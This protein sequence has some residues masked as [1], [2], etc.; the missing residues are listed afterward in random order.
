MKG[1]E[2]LEEIIKEAEERFSKASSRDEVLRL[3]SEFLGRKGSFTLLSKKIRDLPPE[4]RPAFGALLNEARRKL[5]SL[6]ESAIRRIEEEERKKIIE[7][8]WVDVT[9]PGR[10]YPAGSLHPVMRVM[11]EIVD[12]FV[13][14]GFEV[15]EGPEL[16]LDYYNFEALNIPKDHPARDMQDTFYI[17]DEYLLRTHTSPVQIRVMESQKPPIKIIA[18]GTVYRRDFDLTHVPMFHQVEG[19]LV[20]EGV[21]FSQLKGVLEVF[22]K[23]FFGEEIKV[24][25]RPSYFPF[26]EP[27][28][29]VD[30]SCVICGG[31]GCR[32]CGETGWLEIL[33]CG[34]VHPKLYS[35]VGID[36][37][38]YTGFAF[39]LGVERIAMLKYS[40]DDIRLFYE[41]DIRF[42]GQF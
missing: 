37:E 19:L 17:T 5:E 29:E 1:K 21:T 13:S 33:G 16:E 7:G 8:R 39:G 26:T 27:S 42:L 11:D 9:L 40:I 31:S 36:P 25:F 38:K 12:I 15:A 23:A 22:C 41:G 10:V 4:E 30:I 14:M 18:P 28:A 34:M 32:V 24:R 35:Y 2:K 3:K 20:D 6:Y